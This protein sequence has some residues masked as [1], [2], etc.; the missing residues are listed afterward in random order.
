MSLFQRF[1]CCKFVLFLC[2]CTCQL[3]AAFI[4]L[5]CLPGI[6]QYLYR[7]LKVNLHYKKRNKD[8]TDYLYHNLIHNLN[9]T[10]C[11]EL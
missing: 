3:Q 6:T 1:A 5:L 11:I 4:S 10:K 7:N 2:V 9:V 8:T